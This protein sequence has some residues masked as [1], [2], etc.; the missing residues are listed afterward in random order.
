MLGEIASASPVSV[1]V[2]PGE[3]HCHMPSHFRMKQS[4]D[5]HLIQVFVLHVYCRPSENTRPSVI[6]KWLA[7][8]LAGWLAVWT[9]GWMTVEIR[10]K[11]D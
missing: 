9:L 5:P 3:A 4:H 7:A 6:S 8:W 1:T 10:R 11:V 2:R